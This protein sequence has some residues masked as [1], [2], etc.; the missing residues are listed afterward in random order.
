MWMVS[1]TIDG[2]GDSMCTEA[3]N[4]TV[5]RLLVEGLLQAV[6][7]YN[8]HITSVRRVNGG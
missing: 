1:Y 6:G 7:I 2:V 8:Y 4:S 3:P 5:A